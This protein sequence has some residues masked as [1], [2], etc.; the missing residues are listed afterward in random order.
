MTAIAYHFIREQVTEFKTLTIVPVPTM[1]QLADIGT[2]ALPAPRFEYLIRKML[3]IPPDRSLR[4]MPTTTTE[5]PAL[6]PTESIVP[7]K[8]DISKDAEEASSVPNV[9][10]KPSTF[11]KLNVRSALRPHS[12]QTKFRGA[13]ALA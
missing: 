3:N 12:V 2:K 8:A 9:K 4:T 5:T 11:V 10:S 7:V 13:P 1:D 6:D